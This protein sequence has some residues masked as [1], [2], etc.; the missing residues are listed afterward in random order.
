MGD[1]ARIKGRDVKALFIVGVNDGVLPASGQT[2][3]ILTDNDRDKLKDTG[4]QLAATTKAK[5]FEERFMAYTAFTI[6]R[7]Y[8]YISYPMADFEGKSLR[9]SILIP[10]LKSNFKK[11]QEE[12]S[13]YSLNKD[14]YSKIT[15]PIPTFNELILTLRKYYEGEAVEP[16]WKQ[17][18]KYFLD[19]GNFNY[20]YTMWYCIIVQSI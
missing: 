16:Y 8:L 19:N 2:E 13:I 11:L 5:V 10:T 3:G 9:P 12:S 1:I 15:A 20:K 17:V 4:I 7:K 14:K 18:Y 6:S